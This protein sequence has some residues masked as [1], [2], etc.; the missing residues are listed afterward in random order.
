M[1]EIRINQSLCRL[2]GCKN[3]GG[4]SLSNDQDD[5]GANELLLKV[6][7]TFSMLVSWSKLFICVCVCLP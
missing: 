1:T 3:E 6:Q 7:E 4:Q 2:C 5:E